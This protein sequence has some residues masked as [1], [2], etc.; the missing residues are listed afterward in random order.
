MP[1]HLPRFADAGPRQVAIDGAWYFNSGNYLRFGS[2]AGLP[3]AASVIAFS[4]PAL[5][6]RMPQESFDTSRF[7]SCRHAR[8]APTRYNIRT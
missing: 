3:N 7:K 1:Q 4:H 8:R 2:C 6:D 5:P